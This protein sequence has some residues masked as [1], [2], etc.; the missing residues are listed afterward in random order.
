MNWN[1]IRTLFVTGLGVVLLSACSGGTSSPEAASPAATTAASSPAVS[2]PAASPQP[3][4]SPTTS[5]KSTETAA[6]TPQSHGGQGGQIIETG[7]YH[8]ELLTTKTADGVKL[9]FLLQQGDAHAAVPN[10]NVTAQVQLPDGNQKMLKF[11]YDTTDKA[12]LAMLPGT[13]NGEAKIAILSDISGE[14]V[15]GRF[16]LK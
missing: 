10:A 14:K 4:A 2:S 13:L 9:V 3:V 8:L 11:Q 6:T 5:A 12:Y 7:V 15:N 16:T 1:F